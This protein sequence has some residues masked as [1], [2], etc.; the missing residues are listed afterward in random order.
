MVLFDYMNKDYE[1][2]LTQVET[3]VDKNIPFYSNFANVSA[4]L[5][6]LKN[7]NWAGFYVVFEDKLYLGPFQGDV[8]CT[9]I[10]KGK[11]V[12]GTSF[13]RKQTIIVN[14]VNKF[15]GHIACS[16]L[17]KSEIVTPIFNNMNEV[18]G[19]IDIDSPI[20]NRFGEEEKELLESIS[21]ILSKLF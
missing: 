12:C 9:I 1:I 5:F 6:Q 4:I 7:I 21:N 16:S 8:A 2:L 15:S 14:D 13:E 18:I 19:V 10:N 17:S 11:G 3:I 20:F